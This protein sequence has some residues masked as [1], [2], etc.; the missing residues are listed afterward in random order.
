MTLDE[1]QHLFVTALTR[2]EVVTAAQVEACFLPSATMTPAARLEIYSSMFLWRQV[3]ALREDFPRLAQLLGEEAFVELCRAYTNDVPS[4][5]PDLGV[6]GRQLPEFLRTH[7]TLSPRSDTA[8]LALLEWARAEVFYEAHAAPLEVEALA[9]LEGEKLVCARFAMLPS[10][11]CLSL[12]FD[13]ASVWRALESGA[14][15]PAPIRK[16]SAIAVWRPEFDVVHGE[17]EIDEARAL[18]AVLAGATVGEALEAFVSREDAA[19][20]ALRALR[21]WFAEGWV[22]VLL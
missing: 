12:S 14:Q 19:E 13:V 9:N 2:P 5:D 4:S 8:D 21:S 18:A 20:T 11:R 6:R 7:L 16:A 10:L 1:T 3:D 22:T 15:P 17:L